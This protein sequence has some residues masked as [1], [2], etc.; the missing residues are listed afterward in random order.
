MG[1]YPSIEEEMERRRTQNDK[2]HAELAEKILKVAEKTQ[3]ESPAPDE[4]KR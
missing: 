4:D 3:P 2:R 1:A